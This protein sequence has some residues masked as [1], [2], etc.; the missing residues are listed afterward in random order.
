[1]RTLVYI[2]WTIIVLLTLSCNK[3]QVSLPSTSLGCDYCP[4]QYDL[5]SEP[6]P[7]SF[8]IVN[9]PGPPCATSPEYRYL[10]TYSYNEPLLNP[11]NPY[12]MA[13]IRTDMTEL[14]LMNE[15]CIY[16]FCDN[17]LEVIADNI[18]YGLDWSTE[19]WLIYTGRDH[20]VWKIKT[21]GDSLTQLTFTGDYNN[22]P[23]WS[24]SGEKFIYWDNSSSFF[25]ICNGDGVALD[26]ISIWMYYFDW[27][28]EDNLVYT[29]AINGN[30]YQVRTVDLQT[31]TQTLLHSIAQPGSPEPISYNDGRIL[32][33]ANEGLFEIFNNTVNLLDTNYSTYNS[34]YPQQLT[35]SKI[36]LQRFITDTTYYQECIVYGA[37]YISILDEN[38]GEERRI[39]IPE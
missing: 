2:I 1:M 32:F 12:E 21:N 3:G 13:L 7:D 24:P 36:L 11:N 15:L 35:D 31:E 19:D 18:Y 27:I 10:E 17:S 25:R 38:T 29:K 26:S 37:T 14:L 5:R 22:Y 23:E 6:Y 8:H 39:K 30:E 20:N 9:H 4:E 28:D 33:T 16:N 34:G